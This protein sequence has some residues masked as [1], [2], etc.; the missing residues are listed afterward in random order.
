Q[1]KQRMG[2]SC[3]HCGCCIG[4]RDSINENR[5]RG[6]LSIFCVATQEIGSGTAQTEGRIEEGSRGGGDTGSEGI[7]AGWPTRC[8]SNHQNE[9]EQREFHHCN[10]IV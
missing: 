1:L 2:V 3:S 6:I 9:A 4:R 8:N 10:L 7:A 5:L